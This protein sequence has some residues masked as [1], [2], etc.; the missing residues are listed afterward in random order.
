MNITKQQFDK[1]SETGFQVIILR[2][3]GQCECTS[4]RP[5]PKHAF[6]NSFVDIDDLLE[7]APQI[8]IANPN[9]PICFGTGR[10]L[11]PILSNKIRV[12]NSTISSMTSDVL[13]LQKYELLKD[14]FLTFY[15][16][17]NYKFLNMKDY[18][19]IVKLD[20]KNEVVFPI[21]YEN[22]FKITSINFYVDGEFKYYKVSG[23]KKKVI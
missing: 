10:E 16:P 17:Y 21:Q 5:E 18:I 9:C 23:T 20:D 7:V 4:K 6:D 8:E 1:I 14:D 19:A 3:I 15:F 22:I 13:E 2:D 12:E 11:F